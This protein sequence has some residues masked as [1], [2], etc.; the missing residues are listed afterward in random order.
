MKILDAVVISDIDVQPPV[1]KNPKLNIQGNILDFVLKTDRVLLRITWPTHFSSGIRVILYRIG[2]V[3][4]E[5]LLI[6]LT[7][8]KFSVTIVQHK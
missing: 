1:P 8:R 2:N 7:T 3:I 5:S 4:K 6:K